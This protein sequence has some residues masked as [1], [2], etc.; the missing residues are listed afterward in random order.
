M[1]IPARRFLEAM[2]A[3]LP[4]LTTAVCGYAHYVEEAHAGSVLPVPFKQKAWNEEL[5]KMLSSP[6]LL[7][8][9]AMAHILPFLRYLQSAERAADFIEQQAKLRA[10][11]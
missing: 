1:K 4:V 9:A 11:S 6:D 2:A 10:L 3:G 5:Q 8:L 7:Q